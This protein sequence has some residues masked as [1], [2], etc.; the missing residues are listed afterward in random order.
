MNTTIK[1][2]DNLDKLIGNTPLVEISLEY[3]NTPMKIYSK[4]EYYNFSGSIKDRIALY[5]LKQAYKNGYLKE[6]N[7]IMEATSG[8]T[9]ISFASIGTYLNHPVHIFM[10]DWLSSE[11]MKLLKSYNATL[12][13]VSKN[14]GGFI[15]CIKQTENYYARD[16]SIF[17]SK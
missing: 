6:G 8:N 5:M 17:C 3:K 10:P 11:R 12:H 16:S 7:I 4:L 13:L 14:E 2:L 15:G 9:G 1:K